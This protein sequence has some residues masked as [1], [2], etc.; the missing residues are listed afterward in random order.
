M[1]FLDFFKKK[2]EQ[3]SNVILNNSF[4]FL[5]TS[6]TKQD[7]ENFARESY[8]KNVIA[9]RSIDLIAKSVSSV[10]W[11]QKSTEDTEIEIIDNEISQLL[12]RA[13]PQESFTFLILKLTAYL[14]MAGNSF[15]EKIVI[16]NGQNTGAIKE[17]Y[18]KRPDR[19]EILKNDI[20]GRVGG[21]KYTNGD[22]IKIW[23]VN[24]VTEKC[25]LLQ[26]KLFNPVDDW[27]GASITESVAREIDTSNA[28]TE[29][30]KNILGNY[31]R[32]GMIYTLVGA[33][34]EAFLDNLEKKLKQ[35][36]GYNNVGKNMIITGDTGTKAE[37]WGWNLQDLDFN[38]G[39][40][41][42]CRK[43]ATG[44]GIPPMLLGIPG[45]A[46]YANYKEARL[47]FWETTILFY[48]E[49]IKN[50][51]NNWLYVPEDKLELQYD[52][53]EVPAF[54]EKRNLIWERVEKSSFLTV[55]EK[56]EAVGKEE[57]DGG[58]VILVPAS[59]I[60]LGVE[61]EDDDSNG[62]A[63]QKLKDEGFTDAEIDKIL[64][65]ND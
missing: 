9:F 39:D 8:L 63:K 23:E 31:A 51:L 35:H 19:I 45:E 17:L 37:P 30:N 18:V 50:E 33:T 7:Y 36:S 46:T 6:W 65:F 1:N 3:K 40:L 20:T 11:V 43:I 52:V 10:P 49:L 48:L 41:R 24:P 38:E 60:A 21:F 57:Y 64:G 62:D 13:N 47:S 25:D 26:L 15:L 14:V 22:K 5:N 4:G 55:N 44:Y 12:I 61:N 27:W 58:D 16:E 28:A 2:K 32:P 29:W 42:L 53:D 56:R 34:G 54:A 59:M